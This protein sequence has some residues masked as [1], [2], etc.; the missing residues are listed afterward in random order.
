MLQRQVTVA[1][2]GLIALCLSACGAGLPADPYVG[3]IDP[4]TFDTPFGGPTKAPWDNK[5]FPCMA[6]RRGYAPLGGTA[7][8]EGVSWY[9]L[10]GLT[11]TQLDISNSLD[12]TRAF[13][14]SIYEVSGCRDG[15]RGQEARAFDARTDNYLRTVQYPIVAQGLYPAQAGGSG[16][17]TS[18]ASYRPFHAVME[19]KL[20]DSAASRT[21]CNDLKSERTLLEWAGWSRET[22]DFPEGQTDVE[23]R[24]R[25]RDEL[26]SGKARYRDVPMASVA[27]VLM[28]TPTAM[29]SCPFGVG[30][31]ARYPKF[32][33]DP[34]ATFQFPSQHWFRGLLG[35][36]LDGGDLP[37]TTDPL[38]C[39]SIARL[40]TDRTCGMDMPCD[41]A[42]GEVCSAGRCQAPIPVCPTLND[43]Y[44]PVEEVPLPSAANAGNPLL[45]TTVTL[46]DPTDMTKTRTA[47]VLTV[48]A[49]KPGQPGTSPVCRVR[50]YRKA[51]VDCGRREPDGIA[52]RPLCTAQEIEASAGAMVTTDAMG[53][54]LPNYFVHCL[55]LQNKPV[56]G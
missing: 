43:V 6:P 7:G 55:F 18:F 37:T 10:G 8:L 47:D 27:A 32:P 15:E 25:S 14:P 45:S 35:G 19:A 54:P 1:C 48:F 22:K 21:G 33:G 3:T 49:Q 39:G 50:F 28:S 42:K 44:V 2:S 36:Y 4:A 13:P 46:K 52:P 23:I 20:S 30:S 31:Q 5:L 24:F 17:P 53:K 56:Q 29:E 12:P 40:A 16:E 11:T 51:N 26:R 34:Q 41:T 38:V 9:Y